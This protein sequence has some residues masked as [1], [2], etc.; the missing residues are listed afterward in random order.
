MY[1]ND[2][3]FWKNEDDMYTNV[4]Q[5]PSDDLLQPSHENF[6]TYTIRYDT[7]YFENLELFDEGK[8][9][10]NFQPSLCSNF[11]EHSCDKYTL[12]HSYGATIQIG[13]Q[14]SHSK[15]FQPFFSSICPQYI[16][17]TV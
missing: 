8:N 16:I 5:P 6:H 15:N 11:D 2:A 3:Y 10:E 4:F 13:K 14:V 9:E 7:Y 12:E 1:T 17:G